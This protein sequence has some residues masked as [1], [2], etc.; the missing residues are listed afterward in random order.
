MQQLV[1]DIPDNNLQAVMTFLEGLQP[2]EVVIKEKKRKKTRK[3]KNI[4]GMREALREAKLSREGKIKLKTWE[5]LKQELE[6]D[7]LSS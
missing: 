7:A 1:L 4:E 3:E 5:Q 6:A 2:F